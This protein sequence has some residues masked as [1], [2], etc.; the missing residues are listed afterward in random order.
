MATRLLLSV[1]VP[2]CAHSQY[3]QQ[4]NALV[5]SNGDANA[6]Q[7]SSVAISRDG[8]TAIVGEYGSNHVWIFIRSGSNWV[9]QATKLTGT[10]GV[11]NPNAANSAVAISDDGN[12]AVAGYRI[13]NDGTGA[14]WV[15]TRSKGTWTQQGSKLVGTGSVGYPSQGVA[16]AISG[17]GNT[18]AVGGESDGG[19][20]L[21]GGVGAVWIFVRRNGAWQQQGN[22]IVANDALGLAAQGSSVA[23]S[24][25]GNTLIVGG[26]GDNNGAGAFWQYSRSGGVWSQTGSKVTAVDTAANSFLGAS[27]AM[28]S[29]GQTLAVGGPSNAR[30]G[31]FWVFTSS[32]GAWIQQGPKLVGWDV[33]VVIE[34]QGTFV[35]ISAGGN[36]IVEGGAGGAWVFTRSSGVWAQRVGKIICGG[37]SLATCGFPAGAISADA[38]TVL[39]GQ[40]SSGTFGETLLFEIPPGPAPV[41]GAG[42]V[43]NG[44][45]LLPGI[46]PATWLTIQG[47][48]LSSTTRTWASADFSGNNLPTQLDGVSVTVNGKNAYVYYISPSQINVLTPDDTATG[49]VSVQVITAQGTSNPVTT[50]ETSI[51]SALFTYALQGKNYA[52]AVRPDF[53]LLGP[54]T[55]VKPG[56]VIVL[57]GTGFGPTTPFSPAATVDPPAPLASSIQVTLSGYQCPVQSATLISPGLYQL[58]VVVLPNYAPIPTK[59]QDLNLQ[60]Q[61]GGFSPVP[62]D[63]AIT[64]SQVYLSV[65]Q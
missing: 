5:G 25:D 62:I 48:N 45:S 7:G 60:V 29:D 11:Y 6:G 58:N 63:G 15:F 40:P 13:D 19:D 56:D 61:V 35:A 8:N 32:G 26:G 23:L 34:S 21:H 1:L 55:P 54:S 33:P 38:S 4:P 44:A 65:L 47:A 2:L 18:I 37:Y 52:L 57:F 31:A 64:Q 14:A 46:G 9:E 51:S 39:L 16:V 59:A 20:N 50:T 17:D 36:T 43:V 42:Q 12:T 24:E 30:S 49:P 28:S 3:I 53:T 10:G 22:K 27:M 41:I